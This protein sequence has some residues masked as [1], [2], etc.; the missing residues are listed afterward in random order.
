MPS[1]MEHLAPRKSR[2]IKGF[3]KSFRLNLI[4][5]DSIIVLGCRLSGYIM[6]DS[7]HG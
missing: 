3:S 6:A 5:T 7:N 2:Q 4:R 1:Q